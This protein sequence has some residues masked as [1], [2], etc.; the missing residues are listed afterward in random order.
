MPRFLAFPDAEAAV[1]TALRAAGIAGGR[2]HSSLPSNPV[3]PFLIVKRLP[4]GRP[5]IAQVLDAPY[6]QYEA[7]GNTKSEAHDLAQA[8]RVAIHELQGTTSYGAFIT[9]VEDEL[10]PGWLP[11]PVTDTD[12]YIGAVRLYD[13]PAA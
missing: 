11:D 10:G 2:V 13:R 4:I 12:R 1:G 6:I 7:W 8:A 9:G 3:K 5:A